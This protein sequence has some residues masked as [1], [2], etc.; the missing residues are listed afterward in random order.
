MKFISH[1]VLVVFVLFIPD[2]VLTVLLMNSLLLSEYMREV[3]IQMYF[4]RRTKKLNTNQSMD[5][6]RTILGFLVSEEY[7]E[8]LKYVKN[9]KQAPK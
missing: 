8:L 9:V 1:L 3:E 5:R 7:L 6:P 4:M 2:T